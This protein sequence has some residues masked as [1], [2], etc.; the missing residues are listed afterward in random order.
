MDSDERGRRKRMKWRIKSLLE[1]NSSSIR[2]IWRD[3]RSKGGKVEIRAL[4]TGAGI[5]VVNP[6]EIREEIG[7]YMSELGRSGLEAD[8]DGNEA[9]E[10]IGNGNIEGRG[11]PVELECREDVL[12][13]GITLDKCRTDRMD[14]MQYRA[15]TGVYANINP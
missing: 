6:V 1:H 7:R 12:E 10:Q 4:K 11:P 15:E 9:Q 3:L 13:G 8:G 2:S 5:T 14:P